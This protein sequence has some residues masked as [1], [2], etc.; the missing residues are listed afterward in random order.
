MI[1]RNRRAVAHE[2][3]FRSSFRFARRRERDERHIGTTK[4]ET[5][6]RTANYTDRTG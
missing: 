2:R 3:G 6:V 4:C 1:T 5:T